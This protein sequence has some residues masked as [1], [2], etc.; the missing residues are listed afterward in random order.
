MKKTVMYCFNQ[1]M[2]NQFI[3]S[4]ASLHRH[5][6]DVQV[7]AYY[8]EDV[9]RNTIEQ[10]LSVVAKDLHLKLVPV[11]YADIRLG[12]YDMLKYDEQVAKTMLVRL[13]AF[14]QLLNL[15]VKDRIVYI[16][17]DTIIQKDI[18]Q[19][20]TANLGNNWIAAVPEL[21][22]M[23]SPTARALYEKTDIYFNH[24]MSLN[25]NYFNSGVLVIDL[26]KLGKNR[27]VPEYLKNSSHAI[28]PDQDILNFLGSTYSQMPFSF[29]AMADFHL[30]KYREVA[31]SIAHRQN[32]ENAH[33]IHYAGIT[34]PWNRRPNI[35][36]IDLFKVM[37]TYNKY[38]EAVQFVAEVL[39]VGFVDVVRDNYEQNKTTSDMCN[40]IYRERISK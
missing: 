5:N 11:N 26:S 38:Y 17:C 33:I 28:F 39:D 29:N 34:K 36:D 40:I 19:M 31:Q 9:N 10:K 25:K 8:M 4:V 14:D 27:F 23:S 15:G 3:V 37:V 20:F 22:D 13:Y 21:T 12:E 1:T 16:D 32:I 6:P 35:D 24:R 7:I 2:Q 18:S 30:W